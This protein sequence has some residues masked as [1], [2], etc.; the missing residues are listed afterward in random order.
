MESGVLRST[1]QTMHQVG[2]PRHAEV[3]LT[4]DIR[5]VPERES[6]Q[7]SFRSDGFRSLVLT[8]S[9]LHLS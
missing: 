3:E 7:Y 5:R 9:R 4:N 1:V 2:I 6:C 8:K